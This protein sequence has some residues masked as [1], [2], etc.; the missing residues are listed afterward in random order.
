MPKRAT[1]FELVLGERDRGIP[2]YRWLYSAL[3][4]EI[5]SGRLQPGTRLPAT[6]DLASQYKLARGTIVSAFEQLQAEGYVQGTVGSGTYVSRVLPEA[7]LEVAPG[8]ASD[9]G[10]IPASRNKLK[11]S[12]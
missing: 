9:T 6:R 7:L 8:S 12:G 3:R 4:R 5:L 11:Y 1:S 10:V 2:S